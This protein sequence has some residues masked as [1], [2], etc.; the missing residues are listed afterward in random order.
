[1]KFE[2][3]NAKSRTLKVTVRPYKDGFRAYVRLKYNL[4]ANQKYYENLKDAE[5]DAV[6]SPETSRELLKIEQ[7][8]PQKV[9]IEAKNNLNFINITKCWL[10][11]L[12]KK[13][14]KEK[15]NR[16]INLN[17]FE[18]YRSIIFTYLNRMFGEYKI[19]ELTLDIVQAKFDSE[20]NLGN[21][22]QKGNR[23]TLAQVME[24]AKKRGF[25]KE[26]FA[27]EIE[28]PEEKK[29]YIDFYNEKNSDKFRECCKNDGRPIAILFC[30]NLGLGL[31]PEERLWLKVVKD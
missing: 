15:T 31:R 17:T 9:V 27:E 20:V 29:P 25:I 18:Y 2:L 23:S 6:F 24:F 7:A 13:T 30:T 21:S 12:Y 14:E 26:N 4:L 10:D 8:I 3:F 1:M 5:E 22:T 16:S 11:E 19:N 28:L